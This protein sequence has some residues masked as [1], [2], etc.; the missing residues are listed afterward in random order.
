MGA[1]NQGPGA[2]DQA[3]VKMERPAI[4]GYMFGCNF[5]SLASES[6]VAGGRCPR[7]RL[8]ARVTPI[9]DSGAFTTVIEMANRSGGPPELMRSASGLRKPADEVRGFVDAAAALV[10]RNSGIRAQRPSPGHFP[11][12]HLGSDDRVRRPAF[13]NPSFQGRHHVETVRPLSAATMCHPGN[14]EEPNGVRCL[15]GVALRA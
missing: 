9:H 8:H 3:F 5:P 7:W 2:N 15:G 1:G 6:V 13:F 12:D 14:H 10:K 4:P 11:A